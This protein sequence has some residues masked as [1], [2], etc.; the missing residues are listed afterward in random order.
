MPCP[1][2]EGIDVRTYKQAVAVLKAERG[3]RKLT[4]RQV[5]VMAGLGQGYVSIMERGAKTPNVETFLRWCWALET[6]PF[7]P[8][9]EAS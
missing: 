7:C 8:H 4:Q 2:A 3:R 1:H 9:T 5:E 6:N